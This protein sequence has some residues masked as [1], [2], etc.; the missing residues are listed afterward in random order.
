MRVEFRLVG[1][2]KVKKALKTNKFFEMTD[3]L[4]N[5]YFDEQI[6]K[7]IKKPFEK[8]QKDRDKYIV[9]LMKNERTRD[10]R[11]WQTNVLRILQNEEISQKRPVL[12]DIEELIPLV[13]QLGLSSRRKSEVRSNFRKQSEKYENVFCKN[14]HLKLNEILEKLAVKDTTKTVKD[15]GKKPTID[16]MKKI[17]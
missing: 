13:D 7:L 14:D 8:W 5:S 6:D 3:E 1:A 2:E 17:A 15:T 12:L 10:I 9:K 4:I 16:G 11:H